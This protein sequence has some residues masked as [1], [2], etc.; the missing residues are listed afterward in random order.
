M[1]DMVDVHVSLVEHVSGEVDLFNCV[2]AP[3]PVAIIVMGQP[4][5]DL[6]KG[7]TVIVSHQRSFIRAAGEMFRLLEEGPIGPSWKFPIGAS[8]ALRFAGDGKVDIV[9]WSYGGATI[10]H[11]SRSGHP[12]VPAAIHLITMV[13]PQP[14][15]FQSQLA[16]S[17]LGALHD[18][19]STCKGV[20]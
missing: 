8:F 3:D 9:G 2:S 13:K 5:G 14:S 20:W 6:A 16:L 17:L 1:R 10:G 15:I 4:T 7:L 19:E 11:I 12:E 18:D